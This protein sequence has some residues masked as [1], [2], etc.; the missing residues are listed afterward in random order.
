MRPLDLP[1]AERFAHGTRARYVCGCR[2]AD[3]TASNARRYRER[4]ERAQAAAADVVPSGPPGDGVIVR[5][6]REHRVKTCPGAG[7]APCVAG[8]AW[9]RKR[10]PVCAACL[11]RATVWDG[12][13]S[14][15]RARA[16]LMALRRAGVGYKAVSAACDVG[17]TTLCAILDR[18]AP[19]IRAS[20]ERRIL[21][22]DAGARAD[23]A[24]L[25]P[26][27]ARRV[28][29]QI[30][31]LQTMGFRR[32]QIARLLGSRSPALQIA[33]TGRCLASSAAAVTRLLR[34]ARAGEIVPESAFEDSAETYAALEVLRDRTGLDQRALGR[35]VGFHVVF[36]SRP[37]RV[38]RKNAERVRALLAQLEAQRRE[39]DGLPDGW[40]I[41][42]RA[43]QS[44][45]GLDADGRPDGWLWERRESK[46]AKRAEADKL[47]RLARSEAA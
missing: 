22:V 13:V 45:F 26:A 1:S 15:E 31:E 32:R 38:W 3:C 41:E 34:R 5:G 4:H 21:Q 12:T 28:K 42:G 2:C 9:L 16:H 11:E 18:T 24:V 17:H 27:S 7:G 35:L 25:P 36:R 14:S 40:Q 47:R 39:G 29:R 46:R 30:A 33:R 8:G 23:R 6:G 10:T 37:A 19:S 43:L 44:A 20:T